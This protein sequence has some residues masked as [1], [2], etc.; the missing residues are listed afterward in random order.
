MK[1]RLALLVAALAG[2]V[3]AQPFTAITLTP[4]GQLATGSTSEIAAYEAST[5]T[6]FVV[7][8]DSGGLD[9]IS[10]AQP[11]AP[12]RVRSIDLSALGQGA[13][14]VAV[15][16]GIVA[17][18]IEADPATAPGRVAFFTPAG[19]LISSVTVGS[20][21]D[22]VTFSPDGRW[23][24]VANEG[25]PDGYCAGG[26]DPEGSVSV[27]DLSGGVVGITQAR[28][29]TAGFATFNGGAPPGVRIFGPGA[30]VAQDLEPEYIAIEPTS[31]TAYVTLQENN[32]LAVVDIA[33]ARVTALLPLGTKDHSLAANALDASDRDDAL[34]IVP[35]PV[36]G[37]YLPDAVVAHRAGGLT[38]LFTA[39]EGDARDYE[40]FSEE[41]RV[42]DLDYDAAVAAPGAD[43]AR[44]RTT[45]ATGDT[46]GDGDF[47]EVLSFGA[48]SM[49]IWLANGTQVWDSGKEIET[50]TAATVPGIFNSSGSG[51]DSLDTR[52]DDKGPEPEGLA[53]GTFRGRTYAFLGL[54]RTGGIVV[55][56]VTDPTRPFFVQYATN[57]GPDGN[58]VVGTTHDQ[59]PEGVLYI[60]KEDSP[61]GRALL[62]VSH[63]VS[64]T[65]TLFSIKPKSLS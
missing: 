50:I 60:A 42:G 27:I 48:R 64:G 13:T 41:E 55:Y 4:V 37:L 14:S 28:V 53:L 18:A 21:P 65:V 36:H 6:L 23:L 30:T 12:R 11:W 35:Q 15:R 38:Y 7:N 10:I 31:T 17:V 45:N 58:P 1:L 57:L 46:D 63:E 2:P 29:R 62:V 59:G 19:D 8:G 39:N 34:R 3:Y 52:S 40:C 54:E 20:L 5:S 56:D 22:M 26:T 24:L 25:E 33:S 47:D 9:L 32:A 44:L 51:S 43:L 16:A 49:S 61:T